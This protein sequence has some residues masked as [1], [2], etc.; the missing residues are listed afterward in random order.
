[1]RVWNVESG[2]VVCEFKGHRAEVL[3]VCFSPD[4]SA[5]ASAGADRAV[6]LMDVAAGT[7]RC[8]MQGHSGKDACV[9]QRYGPASP[10]CP[11]EGHRGVVSCVGFSPDGAT[12]ASG[13]DDNTVKIWDAATGALRRSVALGE[14]SS[15]LSLAWGA[16]RGLSARADSLEAS[17]AA[18]ALSC[19]A[20]SPSSSSSPPNEAS[21][22]SLNPHAE[23]AA[24]STLGAIATARMPPGAVRVGGGNAGL[25]VACPTPGGTLRHP[26][27]GGMLP[28]PMPM[29]RYGHGGQLPPGKVFETP[30]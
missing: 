16:D 1:M 18:T 22:S 15:V 23:A 26:G 21:S 30:R 3:S 7:Q 13:G 5:V 20:C 9:C 2:S 27:P 17:L 29:A 14:G 10:D 25:T 6:R 11:V 19:S 24:P 8:W 28:T 4:G 12:L